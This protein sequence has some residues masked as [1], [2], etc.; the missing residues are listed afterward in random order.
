MLCEQCQ[1]AEATVHV[2]EAGNES[3]QMKKY[4]LCEACFSQSGLSKR[5][6]G[7]TVGWTSYDPPRTILPGDEPSR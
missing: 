7:K 2:T 6:E 5:V 3:R 1:K 4:N